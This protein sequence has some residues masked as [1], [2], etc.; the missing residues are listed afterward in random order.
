MPD[1]TNFGRA[2]GKVSAIACGGHH[3]GDPDEQKTAVQIVE[4]AIDGGITFFD[5]C[6]EYHRRVRGWV[7]RS[8][9]WHIFC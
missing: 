1:N 6:W 4:E 5:N 9:F 8:V 7:S 3:L 2:D